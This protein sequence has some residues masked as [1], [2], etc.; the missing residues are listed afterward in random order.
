MRRA[1]TAARSACVTSRSAWQPPTPPAPRPLLLPPAPH[2]PPPALTR[3]NA[4]HAHNTPAGLRCFGADAALPAGTN[5]RFGSIDNNMGLNQLPPGSAADKRAFTYFV[6]GGAR[7]MYANA[8]RLAL[9]SVVGSLSASKDVLALSSVEVD[10]N[11][12]GMG[13]TVTIKW[14]GKVR[15]WRPEWDQR[16]PPR[17][18]SDA[19]GARGS[20]PPPTSL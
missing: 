20:P 11:S 12:I 13:Q 19:L 2:P 15:C 16:R 18:A 9:I 17:F 1:I 8:A 5:G 3:P 4:P 6:L 14:R 10:L 7:M